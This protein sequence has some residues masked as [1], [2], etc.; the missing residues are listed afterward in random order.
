MQRAELGPYVHE[1]QMPGWLRKK[2]EKGPKVTYTNRISPDG[3]H[4]KHETIENEATGVISILE[5]LC[6]TDSSVKR[7]FLCSP[8]VCQISRLS[9]EDGFCGYRNIQMLISHIQQSDLLGRH[10]FSGSLPTILQLQDMI[11]HAWDMGFNSVGR[12]ETRG[13]R[14]TRK[15]IGTSEV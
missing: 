11:E 6:R 3:T 14:G 10:H 1:K 5:R 4:Q 9:G 15:F 8:N 7:A 13:I 2:L 12:E